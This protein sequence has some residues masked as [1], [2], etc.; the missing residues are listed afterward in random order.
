MA[1]ICKATLHFLEGNR[2]TNI[3]LEGL[4]FASED[5]CAASGLKRRDNSLGLLFARSHLVMTAKA[6]KISAIDMVS[7]EFKNQFT[8]AKEC[9]EGADLGF[10]S[11]QAIHPS[12]LS[13]IEEYFSPSPEGE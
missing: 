9:K 2:S 10:D 4:L 1:D 6:L 12:Q 5:F 8:L 7:T 13:V 11:K 3:R